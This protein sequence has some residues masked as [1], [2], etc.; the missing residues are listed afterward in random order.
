MVVT[1]SAED[2]DAVVTTD[3]DV[4]LETSEETAE[5]TVVSVV[6]AVVSLVVVVVVLPVPSTVKVTEIL[7][8][9]FSTLVVSKLS[10]APA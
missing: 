5:E 3:S 6:S 2:A 10:S 8:I 4:S 9:P 1:V 7:E